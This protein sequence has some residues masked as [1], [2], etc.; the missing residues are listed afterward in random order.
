[1]NTTQASDPECLLSKPQ[2]LPWGESLVPRMVSVADQTLSSENSPPPC[3]V[4]G[5]GT[6]GGDVLPSESWSQ[7][8]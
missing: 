8:F 6:G 7:G 2:A 1:M 4:L 3:S 5:R